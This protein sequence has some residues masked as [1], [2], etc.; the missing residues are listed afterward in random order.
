MGKTNRLPMKYIKLP[1]ENIMRCLPFYLAMEEYLA[2]MS[3]E[4]ELFFMWQV[5]PTVIFG[6]NQNILAE[7]DVDYCRGHGIRFFRRKSGGG[8]VYADSDNIMFSAIMPRTAEVPVLFARYTAKVVDML[9]G[10]G[11]DASTSGRNDV[12][13]GDRKVSGN[14]LMLLPDKC[15]IHGT[16]LF[17]TNIAHML[18]AISPSG[19]K[20]DA[21][22]ISSVKSRITT[23]RSHLPSLD[24]DR[25]KTYVR[26]CFCG[27]DVL[28]L[29]YGDVA[30][31]SVQSLPYY[32]NEWIYGD[33]GAS[34]HSGISRVDGVGEFNVSVSIHSGLIENVALQGDFFPLVDIHIALLSKLA[35]CRYSREAVSERMREQH[36]DVSRCI[37][38]LSTERFID[39]LFG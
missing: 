34:I 15:I 28:N 29:S 3:S 1:C 31:I 23:L 10:L 35:G 22:G 25:F 33:R 6:R 32:R 11:L 4:E 37:L 5:Q 30:A 18:N 16:M 13:I 39:L 24:I 19:A 20:L 26:S 21:R 9:R 8:C 12:L 7:V 14:A 2:A 27:D 36:I 17:D 38:S